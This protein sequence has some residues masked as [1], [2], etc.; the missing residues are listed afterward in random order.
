MRRLAGRSWSAC[1]CYA[2]D[3]VVTAKASEGSRLVLEL[4]GVA[5][6]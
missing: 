2:S 1:K 5:V 6:V 3:A 4:K